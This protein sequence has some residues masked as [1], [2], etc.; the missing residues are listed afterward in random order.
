MQTY[1][2]FRPTGFDVAGLGCD[3]RQDWLVGPCSI[4]RDS[5]ILDLS[6]W[7][8]MIATF[9]DIDPNGED[10][11][12]HSFGHWACGWFEIVLIRPDSAVAQS[13]KEIESALADYP[14]LS[15]DDYSEREYNAVIEAWEGLDLHDRIRECARAGVSIFAAR[16]DNPYDVSDYIVDALRG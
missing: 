4:T 5:G 9:E 16:R 1:R 12:A 14:V 11:E 7:H 6:N 3:D 15:D 13:A 2:E 10:H 8:S